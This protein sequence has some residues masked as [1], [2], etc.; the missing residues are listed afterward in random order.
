MIRW[1]IK[2]NAI[3][4]KKVPA[5]D[6]CADIVTKCL[7]GSAFFRHR[8]TVLGL[9]PHVE[10]TIGPEAHT[11]PGQ[12][13]APPAAKGIQ[14]PEARDGRPSPHVHASE[15]PAAVGPAH[16]PMPPHPER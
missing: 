10:V 9:P 12:R 6:N 3:R 15:R 5:T 14:E 7:V 1:A 11:T 8:A 16:M 4:L 2:C 13:G